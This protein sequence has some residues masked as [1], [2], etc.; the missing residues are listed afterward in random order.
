M[1]STALLGIATVVLAALTGWYAWSTHR[2]ARLTR[3]MLRVQTDPQVIAFTQRN[4]KASHQVIIVI[5]NFGR[6]IASD[7]S[8]AWPEDIEPSTREILFNPSGTS[9]DWKGGPIEEGIRVLP[10]GGSVRVPW[11]V[12]AGGLRL[13]VE[14]SGVPIMCRCKTMGQEGETEVAPIESFLNFYPDS[15]DFES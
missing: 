15:I 14:E 1:D 10:P 6:G 3:A 11:D 7:V 9:A 2:Y 8:F 4:P 5:K 12:D 13:K